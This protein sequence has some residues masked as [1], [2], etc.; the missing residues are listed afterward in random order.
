MGP[1]NGQ[2]RHTKFTGP[3]MLLVMS[4]SFNKG[5]PTQLS[6]EARPNLQAP[7]SLRS[8]RGRS[9]MN[10]LSDGIYFQGVGSDRLG[11]HRIFLAPACNSAVKI[12]H[13]TTPALRIQLTK[14]I[15][16]QMTF[17]IF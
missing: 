1:S 13:L 12:L 14:G 5:R 16:L 4:I 17:L 6:L 2:R 10:R 9:R 11:G 8:T 3:R 7:V 15:L